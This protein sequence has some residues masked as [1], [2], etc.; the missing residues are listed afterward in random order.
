ME[1]EMAH[2]SNEQSNKLTWHQANV[3]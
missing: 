3:Q 2:I 1:K